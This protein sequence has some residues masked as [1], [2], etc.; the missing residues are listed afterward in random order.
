MDAEA[1]RRRV[2]G[3]RVARLATVRPDGT[4]HLVPVCFAVSGDTVVSA[5]DE[6]P[7]TTTSLQRLANLRA[8][9]AASL[10]VDHYDEDWTRMWWARVDG[11]AR[12]VEEGAEHDGAV[13][14]LR[15]KYSQ[16]E[17]VGISGPAI[18]IDVERWRGWAYSDL[19]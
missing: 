18:V 6:K 17:S 15:A 13:A 2:A 16:Y 19:P 5:V 7:K 11:L 10:L 14:A 8:N 12:V 4:P 3:A 9:P 1:V